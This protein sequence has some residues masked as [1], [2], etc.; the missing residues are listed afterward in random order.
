VNKQT[1]VITERIPFRLTDLGNVGYA[2]GLYII[3]CAL[4]GANLIKNQ[5]FILNKESEE[6]ERKYIHYTD[7]MIGFT[8]KGETKIW[9]NKHIALNSPLFRE[10]KDPTS[11][12][13]N[14]KT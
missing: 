8:E 9:V 13:N 1:K 11:N 2:E 4:K 5:Y 3:E 14:K 6:K 7:E 10:L 12:N